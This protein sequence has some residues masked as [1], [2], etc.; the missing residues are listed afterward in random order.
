M[1]TIVLI[2][3]V[4]QKLS[5][6]AAAEFLYTS[7]L[8]RLNLSY[9]KKLQPDAIYI[10]SAKYG[11]IGL[12]QLIDPYDVTL[13]DMSRAEAREWAQRVLGQL[14][15]RSDLANDHFIFLAG[16]R[17]R[18]DLLPHLQSHEVPLE[19][20]TIGRQ[21]QRLRGLLDG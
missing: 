8:F 18:R 12:D 9:A 11:L 10:L 17:Y 16:D 20:L 13:N 14:R 2:S 1:K 4:S 6:A 3:C 19:G 7:P 5:H 15:L 21:L